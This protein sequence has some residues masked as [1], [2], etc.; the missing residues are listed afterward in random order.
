MII[1]MYIFANIFLDDFNA[2][3]IQLIGNLSCKFVSDTPASSSAFCSCRQTNCFVRQTNWL[4]RLTEIYR[5]RSFKLSPRALLIWSMFGG[6]YWYAR[7]TSLD[8]NKFPVKVTIFYS[9]FE[10]Q[11]WYT[12]LCS[13]II[14][15][16]NLR[17]LYVKGLWSSTRAISLLSKIGWP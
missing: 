2:N 17:N 10:Q 8:F 16:L 7:A 14:N 1:G 11:I 5:L 6:H 12:Y 3:F 4:D 9:I 15:N 13:H